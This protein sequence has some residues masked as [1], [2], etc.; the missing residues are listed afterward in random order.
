M[1]A[2]IPLFYVLDAL[3]EPAVRRRTGHLHRAAD[4][5][6]VAVKKIT[7]WLDDFGIRNP[8]AITITLTSRIVVRQMQR[9]CIAVLRRPRNG[10][11][12]WTNIIFLRVYCLILVTAGIRTIIILV[13]FF[14][15]FIYVYQFVINTITRLV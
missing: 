13:I 6:S 8:A 10:T 4:G 14:C 9:N 11:G 5:V 12:R 1:I 15:F 3:G 2:P 7:F